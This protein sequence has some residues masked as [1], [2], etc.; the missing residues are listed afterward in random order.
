[1]DSRKSQSQRKIEQSKAYL[2]VYQVIP[3]VHQ[4]LIHTQECHQAL[5]H[6]SV[7]QLIQ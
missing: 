5:V 6:S 2:I 7:R 4:M 3:D 1:M